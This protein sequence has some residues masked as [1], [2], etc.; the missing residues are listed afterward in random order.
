MF[1]IIDIVYYSSQ[2]EVS[3]QFRRYFKPLVHQLPALIILEYINAGIYILHRIW[4]RQNQQSET[5]RT[6]TEVYNY[7]IMTINQYLNGDGCRI[8]FKQFLHIL[9]AMIHSVSKG[10]SGCLSALVIEVNYMLICVSNAAM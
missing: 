9:F 3:Y 5:E 4:G 7:A 1:P 6:L 10:R 8:K 2:Q